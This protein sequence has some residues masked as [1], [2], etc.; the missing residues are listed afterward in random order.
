MRGWRTQ[1]KPDTSLKNQDKLW[2]WVTDIVDF[3][4]QSVKVKAHSSKKT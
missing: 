2:A 1:L 3:R 4:V